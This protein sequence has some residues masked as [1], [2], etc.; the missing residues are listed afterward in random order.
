MSKQARS[1]TDSI[2][3]NAAVLS[4]AATRTSTAKTRLPT[5]SDCINLSTKSKNVSTKAVHSCGLAADSLRPATISVRTLMIASAHAIRHSALSGTSTHIN[6]NNA[7]SGSSAPLAG[8]LC[9]SPIRLSLRPWPAS[10]PSECS[11]AGLPFFCRLP[12]C[13]AN[14]I[15]RRPRTMPR[16]SPSA[17]VRDSCKC[18]GTDASDVAALSCAITRGIK[19]ARNTAEIVLR[20]FLGS[21]AP[22]TTAPKPSAAIR[23]TLPSVGKETKA[24]SSAMA[25]AVSSGYSSTEVARRNCTSTCKSS[26]AELRLATGRFARSC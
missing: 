14:K 8:C 7:R 12:A 16:T 11:S 2:V 19:V 18:F 15:S 20:A 22:A 1:S 10:S 24:A 17:A 5:R 23:D 6:C 3:V 9:L 13:A 4:K 21:C 25:S 26:S